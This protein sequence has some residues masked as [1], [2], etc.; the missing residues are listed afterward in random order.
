MDDYKLAKAAAN[1]WIKEMTNRCSELYPHKVHDDAF[2]I[3]LARF[4]A[5][6]FE[7]ISLCIQNRGYLSLTCCLRPCRQL[8]KLT[9]K[10]N[11]SLEYL[12][13]RATMEILG[14]SVEVSVDG[15]ALH[16]LPISAN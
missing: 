4:E 9:K 11:L 2:S 5:V 14:N 13:A 7:E 8:S 12:P 3:E 15:H 16:R 6:L 1:W 10:A